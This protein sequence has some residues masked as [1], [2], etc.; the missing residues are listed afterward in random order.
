MVVHVLGIVPQALHGQAAVAGEAQQVVHLVDMVHVVRAGEQL[1][2]VVR[3]GGVRVV[4][5]ALLPGL[6]AILGAVER[7]L[8]LAQFDGG[9]HGVGVDRRDRQPDLAHVFPGIRIGQAGLQTSPAAAAVGG[10]VDAR[11]GPAVHQCRHGAQALVGGGVHHVG[12]AGV[13]VHL[14]HAGVFIVTQQLGPVPAAVLAE[15]QATF[16]AG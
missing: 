14:G 12:V 7:H 10:F 15:E 11:A 8:A 9:V 3:T 6:A 4:L 1:D 5:A 13:D 16:T 2:V